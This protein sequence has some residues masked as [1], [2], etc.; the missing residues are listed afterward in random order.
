M[1][2]QSGYGCPKKPLLPGAFGTE[3]R[4]DL[5]SR[6]ADSIDAESASRHLRKV[7][8]VETARVAQLLLE[9]G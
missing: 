4:L 2:I 7:D 3:S 6:Q 1:A 8:R 9:L 5:V